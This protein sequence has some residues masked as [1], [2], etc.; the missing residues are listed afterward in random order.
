MLD[1]DLNY[2]YAPIIYISHRISGFDILYFQLLS[3]ALYFILANLIYFLGIE[4][5]FCALLMF[6]AV[7]SEWGAAPLQ[8]FDRGEYL[9]VRA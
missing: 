9:S 7:P 5:C 6:G 8:T 2:W 1:L 4:F 3:I